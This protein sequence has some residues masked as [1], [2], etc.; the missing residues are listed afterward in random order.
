MSKT[1]EAIGLIVGGIGLAL[2]SGPVGIIAL[3]GSMAAFHAMLG[4]GI[5]AALAGVGIALHPTPTTVGTSNSIGFANGVSPRRVIY[6]QFQTAG[7]LTYASFPPSQNQAT[8]S[9]YLHLV[10]TITGHEIL[11]FDAVVIDGFIYNFGSDILEDSSLNSTPWQVHPDANS[12]PN[13]F[14][15]EHIMFEFDCGKAGFQQPFPNLANSD[16]AWTSSCYQY[17]CAKVHVILRADTGWTALYPSG[18][19]PN[20]QFLVT[21]KPLLDP[22][23]TTAWAASTNYAQFSYIIDNLGFVWFQQ[24][25]GTK[26]SGTTRPNFEGFETAGH[27]LT[28]NTCTW[29]NTGYPI[30][31]VYNGAPIAPQLLNNRLV[32]DGWQPG[33]SIT[34]S[35]VDQLVIEAPSGYLQLL[36]TGGTPATTHPVFSTTLGGTTTDG[37]AGWTC[38][39]RSPRAINP[40][41]SALIV[42]D[43]LQ[44]SDAGMGTGASTIDSNS[45]IA[46][47]NV[48]EEQELVIWNADNTVVYENLYSCNGMFDH[49]S[50]RGDVLSSLLMSMA[51]TAIPPGDQWHIFAGS[52]ITPALSFTDTDLRGPI[53]GDFRLSRRD[54]ANSIQGTYTPAYLPASPAAALSLMSVPGNWQSQSFPPYQANGLAGKPDY[55]NTEDAGQVIWQDAHFE[56]TSSVWTAQRLAKIT[57]MRLRF[58]QTLTLQLKLTAFQ[59]EAGDT[60]N[61]TH[62]WGSGVYEAT[63]VAL[64]LDT[65]GDAPVIGVDVIARQTDPSVYQFTAPSSSTNYGEYSPYGVTGVFSGVE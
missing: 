53:K 33:P 8:T 45:V 62:R 4:L 1:I 30:Q 52:Y 3:Q 36:T 42:N 50:T 27:T 59:L 16:S 64:V 29:Y 65:S 12:T 7:V 46:A 49:S 5:T 58:Q 28:D 17:R 47:A 41:N 15:W 24:T 63:Q 18:Q 56:F 43:Y 31:A 44:D 35:A 11:S 61:F 14:Y 6:G 21:G 26:T 10:Y 54:A 60:F 39:G 37:T 55:L 32:N 40:S 38:M 22:R 57:L 23:V 25:S 48:C 9:Q 13:D 20:I 34:Y 2:I 51:G 19:L